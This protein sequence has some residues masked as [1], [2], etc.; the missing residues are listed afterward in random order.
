MG[1]YF[2]AM[3]NCDR[4]NLDPAINKIKRTLNAWSQRD[5]TLKGSITVSKSLVVS[6]LTY[7]MTCSKIE[8]ADIALIQS[9]IMK[10]IWRG[11]PPK[12]AKKL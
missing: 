2:S 9:L 11:R 3:T 1:I 7:I 6:Q 12:V 5:P 4:Q 10:F 8:E